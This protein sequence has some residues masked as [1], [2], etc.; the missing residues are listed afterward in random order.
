[1]IGQSHPGNP[2]AAVQGFSCSSCETLWLK[3]LKTLNESFSSYTGS[4]EPS[5]GP[6]FEW[7][8]RVKIASKDI[9]FHE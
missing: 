2:F 5:H 6:K 3:I 9:I 8:S 4:N 1:M 7:M